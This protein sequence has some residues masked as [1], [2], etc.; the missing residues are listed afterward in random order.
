MEFLADTHQAFLVT[1]IPSGIVMVPG[2]LETS[3]AEAEE[4]TERIW[5]RKNAAKALSLEV[6]KVTRSL[7]ALFNSVILHEPDH[8]IGKRQFG[9]E[10]EP[11]DCFVGRG[12]W[13][14]P[15]LSQAGQSRVSDFTEY[16]PTY[17]CSSKV[18]T[19]EPEALASSSPRPG[20]FLFYSSISLTVFATGILFSF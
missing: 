10:R 11:Q 7:R 9:L 2:G 18:S 20:T 13:R 4:R 17:F 12:G 15:T 8:R 19:S 5:A 16:E 6:I 14:F 1:V 3:R